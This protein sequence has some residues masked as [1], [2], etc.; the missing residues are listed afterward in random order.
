MFGGDPREPYDP[1]T[2]EDL[3]WH[4]PDEE[5]LAF[6][7]DDE[8]LPWLESAEDDQTA[9]G[10]D[11]GRLIGF[12]LLGLVAL[13]LVGGAVWWFANSGQGAGPT[14]DGSL[15]EAPDEPYKTRPDNPGGKVHE[16][17]GDTSF[18]VGEGETREGRLREDE[19]DAS[20]AAPSVATVSDRDQANAARPAATPATA[21]A[22]A[23]AP[24]R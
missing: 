22:P 23:P 7:D 4:E 21:P 19:P 13:A 10:I 2:D 14:P 8:R 17:T 16:G 9:G 18:A 11:S 6:A 20:P 5:E 15:V 1:A 12:G 24:V 3:S